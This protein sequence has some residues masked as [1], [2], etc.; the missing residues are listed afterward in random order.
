VG[1]GVAHY[2]TIGKPVAMTALAFL[3][4]LLLLP[5]GQETR[6]KTLPA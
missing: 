6:G 3:V 4:G 2:H 1:A 5:L